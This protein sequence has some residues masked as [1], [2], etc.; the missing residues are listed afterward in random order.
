M[1]GYRARV[2]RGPSRQGAEAMVCAFP[3]RFFSGAPPAS[4]GLLP[5][6]LLHRRS[7]GRPRRRRPLDLE[8][9]RRA[10]S[11]RHPNR[12]HLPRQAASVRRGQDHPRVR[13]GARPA[14]GT[15]PE[16]RVGR[17]TP[18]RPGRGATHPR[19]HARCPPV[20]PVHRRQP[21]PDALFAVPGP[22]PV[23]VFGR[24]RGRVQTDRRTAQDCME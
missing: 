11:R 10:V 9:G 1:A 19:R 18:P 14:V 3:A 6:H 13:D 8:P 16:G 21:P 22:G 7:T 12:R 17:R 23:R 20:H 24:R 2:G 5:P 15:G 4:S